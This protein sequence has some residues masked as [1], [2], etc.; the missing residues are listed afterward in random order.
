MA[1]IEPVICRNQRSPDP[2]NVNLAE[3]DS[4]LSRKLQLLVR[5]LF[6]IQPVPCFIIHKPDSNWFSSPWN[7]DRL[8]GLHDIY[9]C[10]HQDLTHSLTGDPHIVYLHRGCRIFICIQHPAEAFFEG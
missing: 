5:V 8:A 10:T 2:V 4:L 3:I 7:R 6:G 1:G 9:P